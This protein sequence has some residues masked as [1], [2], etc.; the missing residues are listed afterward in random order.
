[1]PATTSSASVPLMVTVFTFSKFELL[2]VCV[3]LLTIV[4]AIWTVP[5]A[6]IADVFVV[7]LFETMFVFDPTPTALLKAT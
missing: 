3:A 6:V 2:F 5:V 1:M 7:I 4:S